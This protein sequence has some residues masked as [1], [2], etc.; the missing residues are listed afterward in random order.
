MFNDKSDHVTLQSEAVMTKVRDVRDSCSVATNSAN[1]QSEEVGRMRAK[2]MQKLH[3]ISDRLE[4]VPSMANE[5]FSTL[6]GLVEMM[7][8]IQLGIRA[9]RRD[10]PKNTKSDIYH[11]DIIIGR[12]NGSESTYDPGTEELI[13][14]ICASAGTMTTHKYSKNAQLVIEDTGRLLGLMMQELS[15]TSPNRDDL[16]RK[17]KSLCDHHYSELE[18]EVQSLEGLEKTKRVLTASQRVQ[19]FNQGQYRN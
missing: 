5:Q 4:A 10:P 16:P 17:R 8:Q 3:V 1:A 15:A 2:V 9:G 13:A 6:Q 19:M 18:T 14:K 7:S 11:T 12:S